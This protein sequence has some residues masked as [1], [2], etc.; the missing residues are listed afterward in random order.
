MSAYLRLVFSG[1]VAL[2]I[3]AGAVMPAQGAVLD[4]GDNAESPPVELDDTAAT[5][6][7]LFAAEDSVE[8]AGFP[9]GAVAAYCNPGYQWP[10]TGCAPWDGLTVTYASDSGYNASCVTAGSGGTTAGCSLGVPFGATIT[11]SIDPAAIPAGYWLEGGEAALSQ[12]FVIPDGPPDGVYGGPVFVLLHDAAEAELYPLLSFAAIC[13][14]DHAGPSSGCVPWDGLDVTISTAGGS[15]LGTC[16][17]GSHSGPP[18]SCTVDVLVDSTIV[19]SI[20]PGAV[21]AGY[22][23]ESAATQTFEVPSGL[24]GGDYNGPIFLVVPAEDG[25]A[26]GSIE[27][28]VDAAFCEPGYLGPFVGCTP[29]EGVAV[30]FESTDAP[31]ST[32]CVTTHTGG[33]TATC[34]LPV[35]YGATIEVS[36]DP[37]TIPAGYVLEGDATQYIT[38]PAGPPDGPYGGAAF[39]L[40]PADAPPAFAMTMYVALCEDGSFNKWFDGCTPWDGAEIRIMT[41]GGEGGT[42]TTTSTVSTG[43]ASCQVTVPYDSEVTVEVL[44][45]AP[46]GWQ[47]VGAPDMPWASP[48]Q[49]NPGLYSDPRLG[50]I[51]ERDGTFYPTPIVDAPLA[52]LPANAAYCEPG[53]AGPFVGCTPWNGLEVTYTDA[54]SSFSESCVTAGT[55]ESRA[56]TCTVQVPVLTTITASIDPASIPDGYVLEGDLEQSFEIPLGPPQGQLAGPSFVLLPEGEAS[57]ETD[58]PGAVVSLPNTGTGEAL[59]GA[60]GAAVAGALVVTMMLLAGT[61]SM[62]R[63]AR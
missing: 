3:V 63:R 4:S 56:A 38:M 62:W 15:L 17:T 28:Y 9:L 46:D 6:I 32:T 31:I 30:S 13:D 25:P 50:L 35:L 48:P 47:F 40:L 52:P 59:A 37:A 18:S 23:L 7:A 43:P 45:P 11:A 16:V 5:P 22:V 26:E 2:L 20:D 36:I 29:W 41:A 44:T 55:P 49:G 54:N 14:A 10:F 1:V 34:T 12:T 24:P 61:I 27:L 19:A 57:G 42:C 60:P 21:P 51:P 33:P 53:Y 39:V 8:D 58:D